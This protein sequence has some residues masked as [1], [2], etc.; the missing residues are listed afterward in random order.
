MASRKRNGNQ[1]GGVTRNI[2]RLI[3]KSKTFLLILCGN[4]QPYMTNH[5]QMISIQTYRM[6][7]GMK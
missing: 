1:G 4:I 5:T 2:G 3:S 7:Y 6:K